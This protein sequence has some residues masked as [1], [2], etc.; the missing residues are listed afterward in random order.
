MS[1]EF[2]VWLRAIDVIVGILLVVLGI[3][4]IWGIINPLVLIGVA[5]MQL[6]G[7]ILLIWGIWNLIKG[8]LTKELVPAYRTLLFIAAIL[9]IIFGALAFALPA[10]AESLIAL[11]FAVGLIIYGVIILIVGFMD[12]QN[13]DW[14]RI[15]AIIFGFS[16]LILGIIFV[17]YLQTAANILYFFLAVALII[18]GFVRIVYGLSGENY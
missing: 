14:V 13:K 11:L 4:V 16:L 5:L 6:L 7:I 9:L 3:W 8:L 12:K 18:A 17:F 2:P 1:E 10:T 15:L